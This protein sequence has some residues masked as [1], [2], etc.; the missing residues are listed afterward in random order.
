MLQSMG[1]HAKFWNSVH[2]VTLTY[3]ANL[4]VPRAGELARCTALNKTEDIP[5]NKLFGTVI[6][7]RAID[8]VILLVMIMMAFA[9]EYDHLD[10]FFAQ[11]MELRGNTGSE[12][13][14]N[15][16]SLI[17]ALGGFAILG[18]MLF[19]IF[20]RQLLR[21]HFYQ[22]LIAFT[23]GIMD[24]LRSIQNMNHR[25]L[26]MA[27]TLGIWLLYFLMNYLVVFAL[28]E[29]SHLDAGDGL[30]IF[31]VGAMGMVVPVQGGIGSFH[32][33]VSMGLMLLGI[34]KTTALSFAFIVHSTQTVLALVTGPVA[35]V[36]ISMGKKTAKPKQASVS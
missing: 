36:Q 35:L 17:Q 24:G 1:Y 25:G 3:F 5:V 32:L 18:L 19:A 31:V 7:E 29:T 4:I 22:K 11:V 27:Y 14:Q 23:K 15:S 12:S 9:F 13:S 8:S 6:L 34:D 16:I 20:R 28:P 26:F 2:A 10:A 21:S 30:F 33:A